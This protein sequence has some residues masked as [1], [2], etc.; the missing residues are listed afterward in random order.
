ML[1]MQQ[2]L[3]FPWLF[4]NQTAPADPSTTSLSAE[5]AVSAPY[6][7]HVVS[8][9]I[10]PVVDIVAVHGLNGHCEKTWTA[11]NGVNWLRNLLPHD[12]PDARIFSWGYDANTHSS[13]HMSSQYLYGHGINLVTD[14]SLERRV[15]Q[16]TKRPIIFVAHS[17]GGIIVKSAL[18]HSDAARRRAL[19]EHRS[20][21]ISTYGVIFM[22]TP[23][24]GGNG[25]ALGRLMANVA[26]VFAATDDRLL[27]HLE[28]D[29]EWLQQQLG[30]YNPISGDFV[31]K[32]A[33]EEYKTPIKLGY[34]IMVVPRA[35]AV[36]SGAADAESIV[37]H[38]DHVNMVKFGS[39][40]DPGYRTVSRHL[41]LMAADAGSAIGGRWET[42][43]RVDAEVPH[44]KHFVGRDKELNKIHEE[45]RYDGSRKTVVVHGLG[46]MGKTQLA[47]AYVQNHRD[48]YSA[49]FWVN[50]KDVDTLK[51]GYAAAAKRI[52][53]DHPSLIHWKTIA[54]GNDLE[55]AID[56]VRRWLSNSQNDRWL[57]IYDNYDT[58][59]LPGRKDA[60]TFDIRP[61]LPEADQGAILIT[62]RSSQLRLGHTITLEKLQNIN[63]GLEIL[64]HAS[65]RERLSSAR[66]LDGLPLALATAGAYLYH[67]STSFADYLQLYKA[68]WLQ[69]QQKTPQ[70]LPYEDRALYTT[71][72]VSFERVKQQSSLAVKLLQLWAYFDNQDVWF[73]LLQ[74]C[75]RDG[76][77]WC[78]ELTKD[79]L[80]FDEAVRVLCDYALVEIEISQSHDSVESRGYSMHSSVHSWTKNVVND[81]WDEKMAGLALN[82]IGLHVPHHHEPQYWVIEQRLVRHANRCQDFLSRWP[83]EQDGAK[84]MLTHT[85]AYGLSMLYMMI[86]YEK[87]W[88]PSRTS[89][90]DTFNNLGVLYQNQGKLDKA[91]EMYE[92]ALQGYEKALGCDHTSTLGTVNNLGMLYNDQGKLDEAEE[93]YQRALQG[94][95]KALGR[96]HT[97]TLG[98]VNNLGVLY[99]NQGKLD[100]AEEMYQRALQ[101]REKAL[102]RDHT[103]TLDTVN[104]LGLLYADQGK[105][106]KAEEMYERALQGKE[107]ALGRDHTST[108]NTVNNLG[109]LYWNQGKLDEA[110][111]MYQ[112]ALQ[113]REKALGPDHT[114]TLS[115]FN[116]LGALYRRQGKLDKAEEMFERALQGYE[117]ALGR[118]HT[119]TLDTVNNLGLLYANQGKLDKA[120][121]MFE[122][123]LQ[124]KEKA[125]GRDHT[126]TLDTVNNLGLLYANQGKLDKAEEMFERALQGKEKALGR[127][128]TSTLD[129]VNNLGL[130]YADQGKLDKAEEMYERAL[131]GKEKALGRD[132]TSTLNTVNNLGILYA[133]QGKRDKAEEMYQRAL[134]GREKALGRDHTS[135]LDTVNNL[136][137][138]YRRQGKLDK[139]EEMY[140]RALQGYE[141]RFGSDHPRCCS[142]RRDLTALQ[143]RVAA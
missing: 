98:T 66:E 131:Q 129:T 120:E 14:L 126:S 92:R 16:T 12:L 143:D 132:H 55:E 81:K 136:G 76:P 49:V 85:A 133:D 88:V 15:T 73:E 97:S 31:T 57:I 61:F 27:K 77:E 59:K 67:I 40:G 35:S 121:E 105:L 117:K 125:L 48:V 108:L 54:E 10:A 103:S 63:H 106:D 123:A 95:E 8:E 127:D 7:L 109:T 45:L 56:A 18:I 101:G 124:G 64:S 29:S 134:Q 11:D 37:I 139:A 74:G 99:W 71:W 86:G 30:Q 142:L 72:D 22:G 41:K 51:Q 20:I 34:S 82:C 60:G 36:V 138:L 5:S 32:F 79:Q 24:Q 112:R 44:V 135:T 104:N 58:P 33:F 118:D 130:L 128:H 78:L 4:S 137:A 83:V 96:D 1:G 43:G 21:K 141:K 25:V 111:E 116:N 23:H 6:G 13:S 47:L 110:E 70:L 19:E 91:Q 3:L 100:E 107:K 89:I 52:Y 53:R 28:R 90:L 80:I 9:G 75:Q 2:L 93:M 102:G 87:A 26:S 94:R 17:L 42:E 140:Q 39:K 84:S 69:L 46:G 62:T 113:G 122:R 115:T 38:A 68:S 65:G 50:S 114:S 119:S